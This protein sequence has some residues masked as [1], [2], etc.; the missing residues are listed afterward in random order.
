MSTN[1]NLTV[2][3]SPADVIRSLNYA[4]ATAGQTGSAT[5]TANVLVLNSNGAI[6]STAVNAAGYNLTTVYS[7]QYQYI[8]VAYADNSTGSVN[9]TFSPTGRSWFGVRSSPTGTASTNPTDY[10]WFQSGVGPFG[11]STTLYYSCI[12]GKQ[13]Q[14][15]IGT[16]P[17]SNY[18]LIVP[19]TSVDPINLDILTSTLVKQTV[20]LNIYIRST[21]TPTKASSSRRT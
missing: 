11:P 10:R 9:F 18:F 20:I 5:N 8:T 6:T 19:D 1:F 16:T 13:I 15:E 7:W 17:S 12:G 14:F 21:S 4:L 2:S 3:S